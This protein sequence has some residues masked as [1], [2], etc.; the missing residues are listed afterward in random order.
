MTRVTM[1]ID[2]SKIRQQLKVL[3][4]IAPKMLNADLNKAMEKAAEKVKDYPP[5]RPKQRYKR[6]GTFF[7]SVKVTKAKRTS[8]GGGHWVRTAALSTNARQ[9]RRGYSMYVTGD[10]MGRNQARIHKG[11]DRWNVA[12]NEVRKAMREMTKKTTQRIQTKAKV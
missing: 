4:V 12:R 5:E 11:P 10:S 2:D 9:K 3:T 8:G 1:T 7:R 6:T